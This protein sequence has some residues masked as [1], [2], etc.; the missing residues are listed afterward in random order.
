MRRIAIV[1]AGQAGLQTAI[2][3][4]KN[5]GYEVTVFS[6]RTPEQIRTG[7]VMSSQCMFDMAL[8]HE[9]EIGINYWDE[10]CPPV[11]G[12]G[13]TVPNPEKPGEKLFAWAGRLEKEAQAVDQRIKM[14]RLIE[15]FQKLGGKFVVEDVGV[16]SMERMTEDY[17]LV[18]VAAGKGEIVRVFE[19]D[20]D[21]SPFDKPMRALALTYVKNMEPIR[22]FSK[23]SFNLIPGVGEYF[24]FPSETINGDCEIMVFEGVP[25]GPMD[26]WGDVTTPEQHLEK[27]LWILKTFLPWEYERCQNV[28]LTDDNG[29]L[30]GRFAPTVRKPVATLPNGG[31]VFGIA[32]V[33]VVNDPITGQGSNN[34][35]K[36]SKVYLDEILAHGD[37]PYTEAW[38][39]ATFEKYYAYAQTVTNWTN[40]MLTPPPP[41][42][43]NLMGAASAVQSLA[44][45]IANNFS[46]PSQFTPWWFDADQTEAV[47]ASHMSKVAI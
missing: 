9:R 45:L 18:I 1:G 36:C 39:N 6:N 22:P 43:L 42:I 35:S 20:A 41:H 14:P 47:I 13:V 29:V 21:R 44:D 28:T 46:D 19:R 25:G 4:L 38:M 17:D 12:L 15:E 33:V 8:S 7:K 26:C 37:Q 31:K 5:G 24:V 32:D 30:A 16:E 2:G 27:S 23:V 11:Q 10:S 40:S 34:A 3:L